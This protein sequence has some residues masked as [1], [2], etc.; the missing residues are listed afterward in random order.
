MADRDDNGRPLFSKTPQQ[1]S[2]IFGLDQHKWGGSPSAMAAAPRPKF[3]FLV[4]FV[5]GVGQGSAEWKD[6]I[7]FAVKSFDRP[8]ISP[9]TKELNQYN[10]KRIIQTGVRYDALNIDFHDTVDATVHRMWQDYAEHYFGD[11]R[12]INQAEW[13]YDATMPSFYNYGE[14]FGLVTPR[15][16]TGR[17]DSLEAA[18]F[19]ER[20]ECYQ[21]FGNSYTRFDLVHP[22]ISRFDPDDMAYDA[23][24]QSHVI[25]MS[26]EFEAIINYNKGGNISLSSSRELESL[27]KGVLDGDVYKPPSAPGPQSINTTNFPFFGN[28]TRLLNKIPGSY[29]NTIGKV[30]NAVNTAQQVAQIPSAASG[31][32]GTF[33]NFSFGNGKTTPAKVASGAP[34]GDDGLSKLN[35]QR[36]STSQVGVRVDTN[37]KGDDPGDPYA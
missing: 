24:N 19:F 16:E 6:G 26:L 28:V 11:F 4:R 10:K 9:Q 37:T 13:A 12:R 5:R 35:E 7:T 25:R 8:T 27:F 29:I 36:P 32:L 30:N 21:L 3:L 34:T 23:T 33:G 14:G 22:K 15:A 18:N 1:A 2:R 20:V 17:P 31:V